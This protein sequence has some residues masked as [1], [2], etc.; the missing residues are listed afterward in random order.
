MKLED[1]LELSND[2]ILSEQ[3]LSD[4]KLLESSLIKNSYLILDNEG[5]LQ[6]DCMVKTNNGFELEEGKLLDFICYI[7][8]GELVIS[9]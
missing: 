1:W 5:N 7:Y 3:V 8:N 6:E 2:T 9:K 4:R